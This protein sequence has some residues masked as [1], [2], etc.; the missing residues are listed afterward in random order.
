[1]PESVSNLLNA[2]QR[3]EAARHLEWAIERIPPGAGDQ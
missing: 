3:A 1:M 2:Q